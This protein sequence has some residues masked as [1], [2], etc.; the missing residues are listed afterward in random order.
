M[1]AMLNAYGP[2]L[3]FVF[4]IFVAYPLLALYVSYKMAGRQIGFMRKVAIFLTVL[5]IFALAPILDELLGQAYLAYLCHSESEFVVYHKI[6]LPAAYWNSDG[7][8]KFL[9]KNLDLDDEK[10]AARFQLN[11]TSGG[12]RAFNIKKYVT[13]IVDTSDSKIIGE[14]MRFHFWRGW[15]INRLE[16][17]RSAD[18]CEE[19]PD[20]YRQFLLSIFVPNQKTK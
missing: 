20:Y 2:Y 9:A 17:H 6:E 7:S 8:P 11:A 14:Y 13:Q 10:L 5:A 18:S 3:L 1:I 16:W 12:P 19:R 4:G 15:L